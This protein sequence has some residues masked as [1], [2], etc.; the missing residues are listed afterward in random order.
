MPRDRKR[1]YCVLKAK[2]GQF[3]GFIADD[4]GDIGNSADMGMRRGIRL[5]C[6]V[7]R[8]IKVVLIKRMWLTWC[9]MGVF[10]RVLHQTQGAKDRQ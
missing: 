5:T 4:R 10:P 7:S 8:L 9:L 3:Y 2:L 6:F 1:T